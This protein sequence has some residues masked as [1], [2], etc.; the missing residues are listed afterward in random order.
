MIQLLNHEIVLFWIW[1][2]NFRMRP[3]S[4][5]QPLWYSMV[6]FEVVVPVKRVSEHLFANVARG[7]FLWQGFELIMGH[8]IPSVLRFVSTCH[9]MMLPF[10]FRYSSK[11]TG[12]SSKGSVWRQEKSKKSRLGIL[13]EEEGL[14]LSWLLVATAQGKGPFCYHWV[15]WSCN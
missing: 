8:Y 5:H 6:S 13:L 11:G 7:W 1:G 3:S 2:G 14:N 10:I 12:T 9:A 15:R 4:F